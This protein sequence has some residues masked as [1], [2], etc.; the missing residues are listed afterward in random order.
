MRQNDLVEANG[1]DTRPLAFEADDVAAVTR[2]PERAQDA[3]TRPGRN[4]P[5][6]VEQANVVVQAELRDD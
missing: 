2:T 6:P 1:G 4:V 3:A 5:V